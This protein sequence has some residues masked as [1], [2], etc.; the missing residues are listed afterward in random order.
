MPR[1]RRADRT[2]GCTLRTSF[3]E[4]GALCPGK[5]PSSISVCPADCRRPSLECCAKRPS[6]PHQNPRA[7]LQLEPYVHVPHGVS[8]T[9]RGQ[10]ISP[11]VG[12][13]AQTGDRSA[14][15]LEDPRLSPKDLERAAKALNPH[16]HGL[17]RAEIEQDHAVP[18]PMDFLLEAS[19]QLHSTTSG[20]AAL[21][22]GQLKTVAISLDDRKDLP[23]SLPVRDVVGHD[24]QVLRRHF[25]SWSV[26]DDLRDLP[27]KVPGQKTALNRD[28][29]THAD[30]VAEH[31]V[32]R[33]LVQTPFP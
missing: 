8:L 2:A 29:S 15:H 32:H 10:R 9:A 12:V 11:R 19:C 6:G 31:R 26:V 21:E 16:R 18:V 27:E 30:P 14:A 25:L 5:G 4:A 24:D 28:D 20:E 3:N 7:P 1:K 13:L 33:L 22:H 23:P 17:R